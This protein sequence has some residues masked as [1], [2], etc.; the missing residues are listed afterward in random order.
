MPEAGVHLHARSE[1]CARGPRRGARAAS[2]VQAVYSVGALARAAN[3]TPDLLRRLLRAN[4]VTLLRVGRDRRAALGD[5]E[6]RIPPLWESIKAAEMLRR[7]TAWR[8]WRV[9]RRKGRS[10]AKG[11]GARTARA[12]LV[13]RLR[14]LGRVQS[15]IGADQSDMGRVQYGIDRIRLRIGRD[16]SRVGLVHYRIRRDRCSNH[17]RRTACRARGSR[18]TGFSAETSDRELG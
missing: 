11:R 10:R 9:S 6:T 1:A 13:P 5:L 17:S 16:L 2:E 4:R 7:E 14:I 3:V 8:I 18:A 12:G 15:Q